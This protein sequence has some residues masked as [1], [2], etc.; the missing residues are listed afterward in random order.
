MINELTGIK[1]NAIAS[2]GTLSHV[3][4]FVVSYGEKRERE[5]E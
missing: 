2:D 4:V 3:D 5:S 1:I